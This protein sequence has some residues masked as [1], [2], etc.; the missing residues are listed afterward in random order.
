MAA[1]A[2]SAEVRGGTGNMT[3]IA[4][5]SETVN[6][7]ARNINA[8]MRGKDEVVSLTLTCLLAEGHLLIEDVP[9]LGKTSLARALARSI[10]GSWNRIQFT[11]DLLP[12]DITGVSIFRQGTDVFEFRP[13]PV[14]CNV[15]LADEINRASPRT[16]SALLEVMA[17]HTVTVDGTSHRV[18]RPFMVIATQNP[19]EQDGTYPLPEAQLDRFLMRLSIGYPDRQSEADI[20]RDE[21]AGR[22]FDDVQPVVSI[23]VLQQLIQLAA[24]T[25]VADSLVEYMVSLTTATREHPAVL[26]GCSP[27]ASVALLRAARARAVVV[28]REHVLPSD[29]Q[30]VA[31][32][33]LS[34]RLLMSTRELTRGT[35]PADVI[36]SVLK[37]VP[38]PPGTAQP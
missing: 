30:Y 4:E 38:V 25:H 16:Q 26:L 22:S 28:G 1:T 23:E 9:G 2:G 7:I 34:H 35:T 37:S 3:T 27:R 15:V 31:P 18:P 33:V 13:G 19:V 14:F 36:G 8:V 12:G 24:R 5:M 11:P 20:L 29:I 10:G 21:H 6:G 17:E 32:H